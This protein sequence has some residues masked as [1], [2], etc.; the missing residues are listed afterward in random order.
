MAERISSQPITFFRRNQNQFRIADG[1][2]H[3]GAYG[4]TGVGDRSEA[5]GV[6]SGWEV[7]G[8]VMNGSA[9]PIC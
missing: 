6:D 7:V 8:N 2:R 1:R 5:G 9:N 3:A 4:R